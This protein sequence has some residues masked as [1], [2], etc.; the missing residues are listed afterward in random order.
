M[1]TGY[2]DEFACLARE[3]NYRQASKKLFVSQSTLSAHIDHLE[4]ELG[5]PLFE[6]EGRGIKL[7]AAGVMFLDRSQHLLEDLDDILEE[8]R[9]CALKQRGVRVQ[10]W[11]PNP[12]EERHLSESSPLPIIFTDGDYRRELLTPLLH[13]ECDI[14]LV[15]DFP[16]LEVDVE[17]AQ[18]FGLQWLPIGKSHSRIVC[19]ANSKLGQHPEL[20]TEALHGVEFLVLALPHAKQL[21]DLQRRILGDFAD[22]TFRLVPVAGSAQL[23]SL[24]FGEAAMV[25]TET[26]ASLHYAHRPDTKIYDAIDGHP[27]RHTKYAVFNPGNENAALCAIAFQES[28]SGWQ[29]S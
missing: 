5:F 6:K 16:V 13:D 1:E 23:A 12:Q 8:C 27:L 2:I 24:D 19:M 21:L 17:E 9:D 4:A 11:S 20:T 22:V 28:A 29:S 7:S 25:C 14:L 3:L 15:D 18:R 10:I 26:F